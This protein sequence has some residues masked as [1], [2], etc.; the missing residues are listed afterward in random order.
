MLD[1][2]PLPPEEA[3][4]FFRQK[5][6]QIGFDYRDV[7]QREHQAAFTVAKAMRL[8]ILQDIRG[9]VDKAI[10]QG[11]TLEQFRADLKPILQAKGWWGVKPMR[12][13]A[14]GEVVQAQLGSSRRL[15]TIYDTNLRTAHAEGQWERIQ[16]TK[17]ALPYLHYAHTHSPHERPEHAA[18]DGLVLPVDDPFWASHFPVKA[19]G[20][21]CRAYPMTEGMVS[22]RG[23]KEGTAPKV[24]A[25]TYQNKRTG[26]IQQIPAGVD[27]AFHYPPGGRL[28]NLPK[29]VTDKIIA[30]PAAI[31]AAYWA[32]TRAELLP[33]VAKA[34]SDFT[35]GVF[36][37]GVA[38]GQ[39]KVAGFMA[40]ADVA[41]LEKMGRPVPESA[42][43]AVE[44]R[45]M[46]GRKAD[47]HQAKGDAL[48]PEEWA[49]MPQGLADGLEA[50][51][52][53]TETGNLLY[54]MPSREDPRKIKAVVQPDFVTKK[55][56]T[57]VN[58]AR[59][60]SKIPVGDLKGGVKGGKYQVVRG[61]LE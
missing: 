59:S 7:W 60:A 40:P 16:R 10:A 27:P 21:K 17:D 45:L 57:R 44:D 1:L 28:D 14:T 9:A 22:R 19:W 3:I 36:K 37:D 2:K 24:P 48:A 38:R 15:K 42:E 25:Y 6:Y 5:G 32:S 13:P 61:N 29:F 30:A 43:I 33:G 55:P 8:D 11:T 34:F 12:D 4:A 53:D 51:L 35:G 56:K 39:W 26:E 20:C 31:G 52:Y 54:V 46:V 18:W 58:M 41:Y 23:L 50:V 49:A 47:R